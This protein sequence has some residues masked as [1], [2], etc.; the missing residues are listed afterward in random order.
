MVF[1]QVNFTEAC[2]NREGYVGRF[3]VLPNIISVKFFGFF[4]IGGEVASARIIGPWR[5]KRLFRDGTGIV[6]RSCQRSRSNPN[7]QAEAEPRFY[8]D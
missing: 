1:E 2:G 4:A 8:P 7:R 6:A 5:Y 3:V